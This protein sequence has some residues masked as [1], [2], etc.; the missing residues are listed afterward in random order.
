MYLLLDTFN[1]RVISRHRTLRTAFAGERYFASLVAR[2]NSKGSYIPTAIRRKSK[3][4]RAL[5]TSSSEYDTAIA[6]SESE[7]DELERLE[8]DAREGR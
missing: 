4:L 5:H 1:H 6:L 8:N 7:I 2:K 3:L